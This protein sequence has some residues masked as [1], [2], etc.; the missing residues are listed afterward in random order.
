[1]FKNIIKTAFRNMRSNKLFSILNIFGLATGLACSILIFLW[2]QDELSYDKFNPDI[3]RTFRLTGQ[4]RDIESAQV[5]SA[6]AACR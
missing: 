4:V 3:E 1:M 6:F 5:P 2:A